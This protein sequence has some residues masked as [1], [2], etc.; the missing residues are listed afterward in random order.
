MYECKLY[1][2]YVIQQIYSVS[3]TDGEGK[4]GRGD[5]DMREGVLRFWS[6]VEPHHHMA[7]RLLIKHLVALACTAHLACFSKALPWLHFPQPGGVKP[8]NKGG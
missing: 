1:Y 6:Q 8:E 5:E 4:G 3:M 7:V 2:L